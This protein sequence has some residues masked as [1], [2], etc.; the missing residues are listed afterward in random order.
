M[1]LIR[2]YCNSIECTSFIHPQLSKNDWFLI[3][4]LM[5]GLLKGQVTRFKVESGF[6]GA[7]TLWS[8]Q[9]PLK[10]STGSTSRAK[11]VN[12]PFIARCQPL[13]PQKSVVS[14]APPSHWFDKFSDDDGGA[15]IG[16]V[17]VLYNVH[18]HIC[19]Y[20]TGAAAESHF[21]GG[22]GVENNKENRLFQRKIH[23]LLS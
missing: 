10:G 8:S 17:F 2:A 15:F 19:V 13:E 1:H 12:N 18:G 22:A 21:G 5:K 14:L 23:L 3:N 9:Q 4:N 16:V 7:F 20:K 11:W 6:L